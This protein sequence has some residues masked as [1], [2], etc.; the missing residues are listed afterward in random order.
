MRSYQDFTWTAAD[1]L[2][3]LAEGDEP[4]RHYEQTAVRF[5]E[6]AGGGRV[7]PLFDGSGDERPQL[8][9]L[10]VVTAIQPETET[11]SE[12]IARLAVLDQELAAAGIRSI[13]AVGASFDEKHA[14]ESRAVFGLSDDEARQLGLRFGQV[15]VFAWSGPRWSLLACATDR[16]T[17]RS[18]RWEA[19]EG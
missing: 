3:C 4:W 11:E 5:D 18:W 15:A 2:A 14:E 6:P 13:R 7:I 8:G 12:D 1:K 19:Q 16:Q 9:A 10:H 17:H